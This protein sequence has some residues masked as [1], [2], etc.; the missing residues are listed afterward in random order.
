MELTKAETFSGGAMG[1]AKHQR[2]GVF[3]F[4][5]KLKLRFGNHSGMLDE[6]LGNRTILPGGRKD[7]RKKREREKSKV[8]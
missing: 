6:I 4:L 8:C 5:E 7:E 2:R 1:P 3:F